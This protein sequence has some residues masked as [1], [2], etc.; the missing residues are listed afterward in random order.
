MGIDTLVLVERTLCSIRD[1]EKFAIMAP[2]QFVRQCLTIWVFDVQ[3]SHPMKIR[4]REPLS[5]ILCQTLGEF[6]QDLLAIFRTTSAILFVL[7]YQA[8]H[9]PV[10]KEQCGIDL[11]RVGATSPSSVGSPHCADISRCGPP[12]CDARGSAPHPPAIGRFLFRSR[13]W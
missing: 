12:Y 4:T 2:C 10:R 8:P 13:S 5:E 9:I 7:H 1:G 11:Y 3:L 6:L